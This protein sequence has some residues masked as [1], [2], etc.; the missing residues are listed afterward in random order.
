MQ[1]VVSTE[2]VA[3]FKRIGKSGCQKQY[4]HGNDPAIDKG[5]T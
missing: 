1:L 5:I 2:F 4:F 3:F